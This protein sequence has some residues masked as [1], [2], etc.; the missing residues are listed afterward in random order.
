MKKILALVLAMML[1]LSMS[2]VAFADDTTTEATVAP[3]ATATPIPDPNVGKTDS[4]F[5]DEATAYILKY[6]NNANEGM[7]NPAE[8]FNFTISKGAAL[9][10][11]STTLTYVTDST[12]AN[13]NTIPEVEVGTAAFTKGEATSWK[14]VALTLP[15]YNVVGIYYYTIQETAGSTAG[16][17]YFGTPI[18]LK[19]TVIQD[20]NNKIRV[21]AVHAENPYD[22]QG[23][24]KT[25]AITNTYS[26][27]SLAVKKEV[28]GNMGDQQKEFTIKV[29]FNAPEGKSVKSVIYYEVDGQEQE[30]EGDWAGSQEVTLTLKHNETVTFTNIPYEVTYKVAETVSYE[31][32]GYDEP[33]FT[34]TDVVNDTGKAYYTDMTRTTGVNGTLNTASEKVTI[35][36]NK[37]E[38]IDTGI[39]LDN[40]PYVIIMGLVVLAGAAMLMKKRA[41]ND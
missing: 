37:G 17:T 14:Q 41:Y 19:V 20:T 6:Y 33:T 16:V 22:D 7:E 36:N 32:E 35:N 28:S 29:T 5:V 38:S 4:G 25:D 21:A 13:D 9:T 31:S 27:G 10:S 39:S 23:T 24:S 12:H 1:V 11:G 3:T 2:A 30:I 26:A 18:I 8:T 15:T 40:M 34:G